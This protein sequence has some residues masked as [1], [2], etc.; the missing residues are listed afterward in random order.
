MVNSRA[1]KTADFDFNLPE[2]LIAQYPLEQRTASRL[3]HLCNDKTLDRQ[4]TDLPE[5]LTAKDLLIFNNTKVIP[6]R[7]FGNKK[8]GGK[9]EVLVERVLDDFHILAH[10]RASKSP[11]A[12]TRLTLEEVIDATM[13]ERVGDLFKLRWMARQCV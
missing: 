8:S 12:G 6:A 13:E 10:V 1:M 7:L 5:L 4:F 2:E 11:K 3:L 9:V